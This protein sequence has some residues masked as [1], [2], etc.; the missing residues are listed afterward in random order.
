MENKMKI[1]IGGSGYIGSNLCKYFSK[2]GDLLVGTFTSHP[3]EGLNYFDLENP[4]L[5]KLRVDLKK[6][7]TLF[8]CSSICKIDE[9][10]KDEERAKRINIDGTRKVIE[11][12]F[13]KGIIPV[14]FSSD[15]VFDGNKGNYTEKDKTCPNTIYGEHKS[16]IEDF[17]L[18]S[19]QPFLIARLSKI[20]GTEKGDGTYL[21]DMIERLKRGE[22]LKQAT[23]QKI[24]PTH[25]DDLIN[26]LDIS[27]QKKLRGLYHMA[28]SE[29]YSRY[30]LA[31]LVKSQLGITSGEIIP[32]SIKDFKFLDN[33]PL[34]TG[35]I[36]TKIT[37]ETGYK[38]KSVPE[39]IEELRY[40]EV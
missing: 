6:A 39:S 9:C 17:S 24:T 37:K 2:S 31:V 4:D 3:R 22:I 34:D 11:Q 38:F 32:C 18:N 14:V 40:I 35:L 13:E 25:I 7:D 20:Y 12:C 33:R 19:G 23:D 36:N 10:K 21:D 28:A 16:V 29:I 30:D 26:V 27:V 1:V 5:E 15:Y 8:L